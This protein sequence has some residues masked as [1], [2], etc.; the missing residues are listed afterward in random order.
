MLP[1]RK[2]TLAT[3][4]AELFNY[5][6]IHT[7]LFKHHRH[8]IKNVAVVVFNYT[9][10][11]NITEKCN[12]IFNIV[13]KRMLRSA[14][15]NV[16][17]DTDRKHFFNRVLSR[18]ALKLVRSGKIRNKCYVN[19][20]AVFS[21]DFN[22][23]LT[24]CFKKRLGFDIA[25]STADFN[26]ANVSSCVGISVNIALNLVCYVRNN[27]NCLSA[28]NALSF[29]RYNLPINSARCKV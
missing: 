19:E 25:D 29:V 2:V 18:F 10:L 16:R 24:Y 1:I 27:L 8:G 13:C 22:R 7:L 20:K 28:V 14:N 4:N 15:N 17:A 26:K 9:F 23:K 3:F 12:F 21:A 11:V 6:I 5:N